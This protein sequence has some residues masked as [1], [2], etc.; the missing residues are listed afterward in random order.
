MIEAAC[1]SSTGPRAGHAGTPFAPTRWSLVL[2][3]RDSP[4]P[5][6]AAALARLCEI[7]W[8]PIYAFLRRD[9]HSKE[10][11]EDLTQGFFAHVLR[12]EWLKNVGPEKGRFRTFILRCLKNFVRNRP[13]P[14]P[15]VAIDFS[16]AEA[17]YGV[18]PVD[19]VTPERLFELRWAASLLEGA[20]TSLR[21]DA[22][23]AGKLERFEVLFPYLSG[24]TAPGAFSVAAARLGIS[25]EAAR[26][27]VSRLRKRFRQAIRA[28]ISETVASPQEVDAELGHLLEILSG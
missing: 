3:A 12:R 21:R 24:A 5:E 17:R 20:A 28:E 22:A 7:Y 18:E 19:N 9:H 6:A 4:S 16:D 25:E 1:E 10:E 15:T 13:R 26:Q 11:A 8:Y 27:E 14:L 2:A 23:A